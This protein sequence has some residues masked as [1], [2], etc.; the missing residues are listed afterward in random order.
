MPIEQIL[1]Q[2][3]LTQKPF[4]EKLLN[5]LNP[6]VKNQNSQEIID[7]YFDLYDWQNSISIQGL[8]KTDLFK[9]F[10]RIEDIKDSDDSMLIVIAGL[11]QTGRESLKNLILYKIKKQFADFYPLEH[12]LQARDDIVN[13]KNIAN[14]FKLHCEFDQEISSHPIASKRMNEHYLA[15][16]SKSDNL[17]TYTFY[18]IFELWKNMFKILYQRGEINAFYKRPR[19]LIL[20]SAEEN[21]DKEFWQRICNSACLVF[22]FI[23][24]LTQD[25]RHA[26]S[27]YERIKDKKKNIVLIK[28]Q[29]FNLEL[30][31]KY[32]MDRL[33]SVSIQAPPK[34]NPLFPFSEQVLKKAL[35]TPGSTAKKGEIPYWEIGKLNKTFIKVIDKHIANLLQLEQE[36]G[37][38]NVLP[39]DKLLI[40]QEIISDVREEI[41]QGR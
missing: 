28:T 2:L 10:P 34:S 11:E 27:F 1:T 15:E 9:V 4:S 23:I 13:L 20:R 35:Y 17:T 37:M 33:K 6:S 8:S 38:A 25:L 16:T 40:Q 19:V 29:V 22:D 3:N 31:Q 18:G 39:E 14:L 26:N 36:L 5:T 12:N 7:L 30:T 21:D 41:N 24:I 32:L